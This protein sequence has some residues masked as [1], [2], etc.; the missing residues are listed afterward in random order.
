MYE[1]CKLQDE[2][3][4]KITMFVRK[5]SSQGLYLCGFRINNKKKEVLGVKL[6]LGQNVEVLCSFLIIF[7][8]FP[9]IFPNFFFFFEIFSNFLKLYFQVCNM[10][11]KKSAMYSY[12][13]RAY[14]YA[15]SHKV[16]NNLLKYVSFSQKI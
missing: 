2:I 4:S 16:C 9:L 1:H 10:F 15:L 11:R 7:S 5:S 3:L 6:P 14:Y 13:S 8:K 12:A